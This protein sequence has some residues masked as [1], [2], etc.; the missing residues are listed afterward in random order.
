MGDAPSACFAP[1]EMEAGAVLLANMLEAWL[2]DAANV[3]TPEEA[4][5]ELENNG[6]TLQQTRLC[7]CA[8]IDNGASSSPSGEHRTSVC[9]SRESTGAGMERDGDP[10]SRPGS[11][12]VGSTDGGARGLQDISERDLA[13]P[14]GCG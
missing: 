4:A 12:S 7:L 13:G 10:H 8:P 2:D 3:W 5:G 11:R 14:G 6:T 9:P 1:S